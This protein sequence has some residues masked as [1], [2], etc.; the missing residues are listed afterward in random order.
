VVVLGPTA[1]DARQFDWRLP[2]ALERIEGQDARVASFAIDVLAGADG[3]RLPPGNHVAYLI[4][5]Q[6]IVGPAPFV[7]PPGR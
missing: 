1:R 5:G 3:D 2:V 7:V 4:V 6:Q